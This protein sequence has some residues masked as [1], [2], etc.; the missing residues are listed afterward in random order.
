MEFSSL[1]LSRSAREP[2]FIYKMRVCKLNQLVQVHFD[3]KK[4]AK[5]FTCLGGSS[6]LRQSIVDRVFSGGSQF[7]SG[8]TEGYVV[9]TLLFILSN[10][11]NLILLVQESSIILILELRLFLYFFLLTLP[12]VLA[13]FFYLYHHQTTTPSLLVNIFTWLYNQADFEAVYL[14]ICSLHWDSLLYTTNVNYS[15]LHLKNVS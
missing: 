15:C 10:C 13:H 8:V 4:T 2:N 7:L 1:L 5:L 14:L 3:S 11:F 9:G 12:L 6:Q